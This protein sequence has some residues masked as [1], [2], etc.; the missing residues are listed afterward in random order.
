MAASRNNS[1][2]RALFPSTVVFPFLFSPAMFLRLAARLIGKDC[3]SLGWAP[4]QF[5]RSIYHGDVTRSLAMKGS[6][7]CLHRF[8]SSDP[9]HVSPSSHTVKLRRVAGVLYFTTHIAIKYR[10]AVCSINPPDGFG[11]DND[12]LCR[13]GDSTSKS[14]DRKR[15]FSPTRHKYLSRIKG[16]TFAAG[17]KS[18]A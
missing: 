5:S 18:K 6:A 11:D 8:P 15:I 10:S 17:K 13:S 4:T 16:R 1:R 9:F 12:L 2:G 14:S 3:V 7:S